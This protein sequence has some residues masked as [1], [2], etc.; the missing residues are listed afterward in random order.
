MNTK[1]DNY[2]Y[3]A[4]IDSDGNAWVAGH[5]LIYCPTGGGICTQQPYILQWNG[6][7]FARV[8]IPDTNSYT[9]ITS[10]SAQSP[11]NR[12]VAGSETDSVT[13]QN[14]SLL[15]H[16]NGVEWLKDPFKL[17]NIH[18]TGIYATAT[19]AWAVGTESGTWKPIILHNNNGLWKQV[20]ISQFP[21]NM[22]LNAVSGSGDNDVWV[23]GYYKYNSYYTTPYLLHW[24]GNVW[25]F[26]DSNVENRQTAITSISVLPN[27]QAWLGGSNRS[28]SNTA[29]SKPLVHQFGR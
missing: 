23:V 26:Y 15:L 13:R 6:T 16:W 5:Y 7:K 2:L 22:R 10:I 20:T 9:T 12:W 14:Q 24:N 25:S 3:A 19:Q 11:T 4:S 18:L 28:P 21:A 1:G 27:G 17:P 8:S 29:D